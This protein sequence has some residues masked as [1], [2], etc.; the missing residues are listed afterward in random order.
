MAL[1]SNGFRVGRAGASDLADQREMIRDA[2]DE[3]RR[4]LIREECAE[5]YSETRK[6]YGKMFED[7]YDSDA[8][9]EFG[10]AS[11][12]IRLIKAWIAQQEAGGTYRVAWLKP[13]P[14]TY[15][16]VWTDD[17]EVTK[18]EK[19]TAPTGSKGGGQEAMK[20]PAGEIISQ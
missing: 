3:E 8:V 4:R 16:T 19:Q 5:L 6:K 13:E 18:F 12:R 15:R 1:T 9:P 11:E 2:Q 20:K 7:W 17:P 14:P 10:P